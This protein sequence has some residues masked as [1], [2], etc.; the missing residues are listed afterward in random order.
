MVSLR[1]LS[2]ETDKDKDS[3]HD[4]EVPGC[5]QLDL[6]GDTKRELQ[7]SSVPWFGLSTGDGEHQVN[8]FE[9]E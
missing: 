2:C 7:P 9:R 6:D 1:T 3:F 8:S 5:L 4:S